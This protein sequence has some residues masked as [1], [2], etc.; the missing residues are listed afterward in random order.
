MENK[1][2]LMFYLPILFVM[3]LI[4]CFGI[5]E[6]YVDVKPGHELCYSKNLNFIKQRVD[7]GKEPII[8]CT[9][10]RQ[11]TCFDSETKEEIKCT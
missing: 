7:F 6:S 5:F 9:N 11:V 4:T 2:F 10:G 8:K 1:K 3:L